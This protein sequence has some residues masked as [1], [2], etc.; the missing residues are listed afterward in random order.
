MENIIKLLHLEDNE[1]DA[2]LVQKMLQKANI[3]Y[4]YT[5][6]DNEEDYC[7]ALL[8]KPIDIILSDY[9]LP[10]YSGTEALLL[11]KT[12][13]PTIPFVFVSG[14]MGEDIAIES[15]LNGATDYVLKNRLERIVPAIQRAFKEA[16]EHKARQAAEN[17]LRKLSRAVEQSPNSIIIT[18][19]EGIIEYAN[20]T[21]LDLTGY[22]T[23]EL[24]GKNPRILSSGETSAEEYA[25]LW[26]TIRAGNV[27]RGEFHNVKKNGELYWE[28]ATIAPIF[29]DLGEITNFLAI[30]KDNTRDKQL[31][32]ELI[33]AKEKA[34]ESDRLKSA[35]L[36]NMSHEIRTP[37]NGILGFA[38]LLKTPNLTGEQQQEYI[39]IIEK[40]G[41]RMLNIINDI[42]DISK[43]ESG[44]MKVHLSETKINEQIEFIYHFFKPEL[45]SKGIQFAYKNHLSPKDATIKTDRE[46]VYAILINLVKN[47][48]KFTRS[49]KIE[50]GYYLKTDTNQNQVLEFFVQ[51]TGIGIPTNRQTA[52]FDR[53][54][55]ADIADSHAFQGAGLGLS[56]SKAYVEMLGGKIWVT[57]EE[58]KGSTFY[59]TI[60]YTGTYDPQTN[61]DPAFITE[62]MKSIRRIKVLITDDDEVSEMLVSIAIKDVTSM[63]LKAKTGE[64]TVRI[65]REHPD[66]DLILMDVKMPVMDG[67]EATREIRKFN[68]NVIIFAN[69]AFALAGHEEAALAAGCNEY[70]SKPLDVSKLKGCLLKYFKQNK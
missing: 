38:D 53:F 62:S 47:A 64:D 51:D 68:K 61:T 29:N 63:V 52:I 22:T 65:C 26:S 1:A 57:S 8:N 55:Q 17:D 43:I 4:E 7:N 16:Q 10:D 44:L 69:T 35:F 21:S 32:Q 49:G 42:V 56:I 59:F 3:K 27:W 34:E 48:I 20:P 31:T 60:P 14:T 46:K 28:T 24:I 11:A 37:M 39:S 6:V 45:D 15:L 19:T 5:F 67:Y 33:H 9:H 12:K 2:L 18:N 41:A 54:V 50:F 58:H 66:I 23:E 70:L 40:S 30:K 13:Y 36:A 25:R